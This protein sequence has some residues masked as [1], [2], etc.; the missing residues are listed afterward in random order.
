VAADRIRIAEPSPAHC[1][2]CFSAKPTQAHVDFGAAW[3]GPVIGEGVT[4]HVIDDLIICSDCLVRA[5][6]LIGLGDV[7]AITA[8]LRRAEEEND[9]LM[10]SLAALRSH[11]QALEEVLNGRPNELLDPPKKPAKK[12]SRQKVLS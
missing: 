11:V 9:R 5:G 7:T 1:S 3:D 4:M 6:T 8:E 2:S 10:E 12:L